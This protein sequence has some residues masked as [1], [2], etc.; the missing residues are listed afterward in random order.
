MSETVNLLLYNNALSIANADGANRELEIYGPLID[1]TSTNSSISIVSTPYILP[2]FYTIKITPTNTGTI[3]LKLLNQSIPGTNDRSLSEISYLSHGILKSNVELDV[4]GELKITSPISNQVKISSISNTTIVDR[5][6]AVRTGSILLKP[7]KNAQITNAVGNGSTVTFTGYNTFSIGDVIRT[8]GISPNTYEL[9]GV[10]VTSATS[11]TFTVTST[12]VGTYSASLSNG[13]AYILPEVGTGSSPFSRYSGEDVSCDITYS[14]TGHSIDSEIYF[15]FPVLMDELAF[16]REWSVRSTNTVMPQVYKDIDS[17]S[18]PSFPLAKL[19]SALMTNVN[20]IS[21]LYARFFRYDLSEM[22]A[23]VDG[24]EKW[25]YSELVDRESVTAKNRR[26]LGQFTGR[27]LIDNIHARNF[28]NGAITTWEDSQYNFHQ[29]QLENRY[30]GTKSGSLEAVRGTIS[31]YLTGSKFISF[32]N[33]GSFNVKIQT[34]FAE[35]LGISTGS[36]VTITA[37]QDDTNLAGTSASGYVRFT[38]ANSL[39]VNDWVSIYCTNSDGTKNDNYSNS[40]VQVYARDANYFV[41]SYATS[42]SITGITGTAKPLIKVTAVDD[43]ADINGLAIPGYVR[44]VAANTFSAGDK[45]SFIGAVGTFNVNDATVVAATATHFVVAATAR[46][47]ESTTTGYAYA[48]SSPL[49]LAA[50]EQTR[51][52]GINYTSQVV[53][54]FTKFTFNN[55]TTGIID[56]SRLG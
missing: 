40:A 24:T 9:N 44:Y 17:T 15:T 36:T 33:Q 22:P 6:N 55:A 19:M 47:A 23:Y 49:V 29:W 38:A 28:T 1:W 10:T 32:S 16:Q 42:G 34:L 18:T 43:Q 50:V 51:P 7:G 35:T 45:V 30:F 11:A 13:Y 52:M 37:V 12:A 8:H 25:L 41:I 26:W 46:T 3:L 53:L 54:D 48:S 39:A 5:F 31:R 20:N 14:I 4:S 2:S 21:E 27:R 56:T